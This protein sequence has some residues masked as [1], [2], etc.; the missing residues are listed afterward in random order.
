MLNL[1]KKV[2]NFS[3]N[4]YKLRKARQILDSRFRGNDKREL[5]LNRADFVGNY[6]LSSVS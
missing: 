3:V 4:Y 5:G 6:T 2:C 1:A